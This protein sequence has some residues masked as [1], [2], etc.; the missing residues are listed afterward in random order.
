MPAN[1]D[2]YRSIAI[3]I[4]LSWSPSTDNVGVAGY[5]VFRN[6]AQIGYDDEHV[7]YGFESGG[8]DNVFIYCD[9]VRCGRKRFGT[10]NGGG[11]NHFSGRHQPPSVP[12][13]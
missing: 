2:R 13:N 9:G 7:L 4:N 3:Q 12:T 8:V 10:I 5:Q 6:G 1:L 11:G